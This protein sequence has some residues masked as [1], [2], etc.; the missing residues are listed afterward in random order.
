M[1]DSQSIYALIRRLAEK[2]I[3]IW[4]EEDALK[5][6]APKGALDAELKNEM[7]EQKPALIQFLKDQQASQRSIVAR[8]DKS[9]FP[10]SNAQ[11]RLWFIDQFSSDLEKGAYNI[12]VGLRINGA[13]NI[14][15]LK[16]AIAQV[17]ENHEVL[18]TYFVN[19]QGLPLQ[20]KVTSYEVDI[21]I[22]DIC[23]LTDSEK[24][25][26]SQELIEDNLTTTFDLSVWPLFK[27]DLIQLE[28]QRFIFLAT[29]HHIISDGWSME[30]LIREIATA[31]Q[32]YV[33]KDDTG[34]AVTPADPETLQYSD[35]AYWQTDYLD[36][37]RSEAQLNFWRNYLNESPVLEL[38]L[39]YKRVGDQLSAG[40]QKRLML[41][42]VLQGK[43]NNLASSQGVTLF[44]VLSAAF[45]ILLS[46]F[47][48]Q[49]DITLGIPVA[50][51][52]RPEWESLIGFFVNTL[53]LRTDLT[54]DPSFLSLL[55]QVQGNTLAIYSNQDLPFDR[56]V[57]ALVD[58]RD[59]A[60]TPLFQ[61]MFSLQNTPG[62]QRLSLSGLDLEVLE[63]SLP[64]SRFDMTWNLVEIEQGI[65]VNIEYSSDLFDSETMDLYFEYFGNLL[66]EIV[67][68]PQRKI[69]TYLLQPP[70][71][72]LAKQA[73]LNP[74]SIDY[75]RDKFIGEIFD[76][77]VKKFP[78]NSAL[79]G[80]HLLSSTSAQISQTYLE[81]K[82]SVNRLVKYLHDE[83]VRPNTRVLLMLPRSVEMTQCILALSKLGACYVPI[84]PDYPIERKQYIQKDSSATLLITTQAL[85][86]E[87][88]DIEQSKV[89]FL[90]DVALSK[91][92]SSNISVDLSPF[93][94][95]SL[96]ACIFYTSGSTG[97]PK[98]VIVPHRAIVRLVSNTNFADY[99]PNEVVAHISN[100]CFDASSME[101]WGAL[102]NGGRL[103]VIDQDCLLSINAFEQAL[104]EQRISIMF[105]SMGLFRVYANERPDMF[106]GLK[107]LLIGGEAVDLNA[108]QKVLKCTS[109]PSRLLNGYGPTENATFSTTFHI[110]SIRERTIS[111]PLGQAIHHSEAYITDSNGNLL[112]IGLIGELVCAGDG[113]ALGYLN[114]N[115]LSEEK[116]ITGY[117][118]EMP[119][120]RVYRS[121]DLA[122]YNTRGELILSGRLDE[123]IKLRGFRIEP[124]EISHQIE[125]FVEVQACCVVLKDKV[126]GEPHLV[127]YVQTTSDLIDTIKEQSKSALPAYMLPTYFEVIE[128]LPINAN[129]KIDKRAL[130]DPDWS[131]ESG[132]DYVAPRSNIERALA[133]I[134]A[135]L[136][137][138]DTPSVIANFFDLGG[139]S[140]LATQ[141]VSRIYDQ[142]SLELKVKQIF[143]HATIEALAIYIS[144]CGRATQPD[145]ELTIKAVVRESSAALSNAQRR[146]WFLHQLEPD[147]TAYGMP[148][149]ISIKG[150]LD[151][152]RLEKSLSSLVQRHES[153]RTYFVEESG[154]PR[155][156]IHA[157]CKISPLSHKVV[158]DAIELSTAITNNQAI[159]FNLETG[160]L[161]VVE[162][163]SVKSG[164]NKEPEF[165]LLMNMHH[166][167]SDGWSMQILQ[168]DLL[169][170]YEQDVD[171][172]P[173][174]DIQYID[175]AVWQNSVLDKAYNQSLLEHWQKELEGVEPVLHLPSTR[176]RPQQQS[177]SG[178]LVH[179]KINQD[180]QQR[181]LTYCKKNQ[182][183]SF[184]LGLSVYGI[185]LSKYSQQKDFCI[186]IPVSGRN[187]KD[188]ENIIGFFVNG[189][190]VRNDLKERLS[191]KD[192]VD[193]FKR[194]VLDAFSHQDLS[195]D[196]LVEAMGIK[197]SSRYQPLAQVAFSH[198]SIAKQTNTTIDNL[199]F[200]VLESENKSAK[201]DLLLSLGDTGER[202]DLACEFASDLF[203]EAWVK[204]FLV[205]YEFLI[206]AVISDDDQ[207]VD[208]LSWYG[209]SDIIEALSEKLERLDSSSQHADDLGTIL[210]AFPLS[211]NQDALYLDALINPHSRQNSIANLL[212]INHSID[213]VLWEKAFQQC[214]NHEVFRTE[215]M[216]LDLLG[217]QGVYQVIREHAANAFSYVDLRDQNH[218]FEALP[219]LLE[220][221]AYCLYD[222][223]KGPL[224]HYTLYQLGEAHFAAMLCAHHI[225]FDGI[226][227]KVFLDE[228]LD[229]Y[230]ALLV[231]K[232]ISRVPDN[233]QAFVTKQAGSIDS[234]A[235]IDFWARQSKNVEPLSCD[236][237]AQNVSSK[238]YV[239]SKISLSEAQSKAVRKFC[240]VH[241]ITPAIFFKALYALIVYQ[242]CRPE[243]DFH[244][245]EYAHGRDK[246]SMESYG[247]YY[248]QTP[249]IVAF[250]LFQQAN[251]DKSLLEDILVYAKRFQKQSRQWKDISIQA[252][253][254]LL[255]RSELGFIYNY[256]QFETQIDVLGTPAKSIFMSPR[257]DKQVQLFIREHSEH[258]E[259]L[260]LFSKSDFSDLRLLE[261][262]K[263]LAITALEEKTY[264]LE[265]VLN[266]EQPLLKSQQHAL[267]STDLD[268]LPIPTE[269]LLESFSQCSKSLTYANKIAV[270][271]VE[272][273]SFSEL[274][275]RS[276][277]LAKYL[278]EQ[279]KLAPQASVA[280]HMPLNET[281]IIAL[282]ALI[283][284]GLS[285]VPIQPDYP[286]ERIK[287]IV[288]TASISLVIS[289][290]GLADAVHLEKV[291]LTEHIDP[292]YVGSE[293]VLL[294]RQSNMS[295]NDR[296]YTIFTSGSTGL[297]KGA[298]VS[299]Q[300]E[301]N[302]LAWYEVAVDI[303]QNDKCIVIS[304]PGFDLTQ[305]NLFAFLRKGATLLLPDLTI[306]DPELIR[307]CIASEH[308]THI[309]CAPSAF[310][311]LL[312]G[313]ES[314]W[315]QLASLRWVVLGGEP[316][317]LSELQAWYQS[318]H[319]QARLMNSYGPT[320]CSD[321][322]SAYELSDID[323]E[324][325]DPVPLGQAIDNTDIRI[326]DRFGN[327]L[328]PGLVGEIAIG[329][330]GL[331]LGYINNPK[332]NT[333][334][335]VN[336]HRMSSTHARDSKVY[337]SGDLGRINAKG[338][339]EIL[340]R[341]DFQIK[342]RGQRIELSEIETQLRRVSS[343]RDALVI[344]YQDRLI[345][346][347]VKQNGAK[348]D[349]DAESEKQILALLSESLPSYMLPSQIIMLDAWPLN[350]NGKIERN[351]LPEP[352]SQKANREIIKARDEYEQAL[353]DIWSEV[354]GIDEISIL[355]NFF[356]L[357][358]H[359]LLATKTVSR[360]KEHFQVEFPL[361]ALFDLH[362][363]ADLAEYIKTLRWAID[364]KDQGASQ[365]DPNEKRDEGFL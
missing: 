249:F 323:F 188:V 99:G 267:P 358:G 277:T 225:I 284:A 240:R 164:G 210:N 149:A 237:A 258:F 289:E 116:F 356:D 71:K 106:S 113:L 255:P 62:D 103:H 200:E 112:P 274:D 234:Q 177:F 209:Q 118:K 126:P 20:E 90:E 219:D 80:H 1:I 98:G 342:L 259:F 186:G 41:T 48:Q 286:L 296:L 30:V 134:W 5:F 232:T 74:P 158:S 109:P 108:A 45:N 228:M 19:R 91:E 150:N 153:L 363:L 230:Q 201:Y 53:V 16:Y 303:G 49:N 279:R 195:A 199:V 187:Q 351:S 314:S 298:Q 236:S 43:L 8:P 318:A 304:A 154:E 81:L 365:L 245:L 208:R 308:V 335:F 76:E 163:L 294:A 79:S 100:V 120:K 340:G 161:F 313:G 24:A 168:Q 290:L 328:P 140:L 7:I 278:I 214:Q 33:E 248:Q 338:L 17:I 145:D 21:S 72:I 218:S 185:L 61:V 293:S 257:A 83:G 231:Q 129:G 176:P 321:V 180:L 175:F 89:L 271:G 94:S 97:E 111:I 157:D 147:S 135:D 73:S 326:L 57:E 309:N 142:F 251:F 238:A 86:S 31:Y 174:L 348:V 273:I 54:G 137:T 151:I 331:G 39:D 107:D 148:M 282:Y 222:I 93:Q 27:L 131:S 216:E 239:Q 152:P 336:V 28:G 285:Y 23:K 269:F 332:L 47:S 324:R 124:S 60:Y 139:H 37:Q 144:Q 364:A 15:A 26:Q 117:I 56:V 179:H 233:F 242:Y 84:D 202:L 299:H 29:M 329:G 316:L 75:P 183:T 34:L 215:I 121:G 156:K 220:A 227:G 252:Q 307:K 141:L 69:S 133:D 173:A 50:N 207:S 25:L 317:V 360:V 105:L 354:L 162:L 194:K 64:H 244:I 40:K 350:A 266:S 357:G 353:V 191:V 51:R 78:Q 125:Q 361:K 198:Q 341:K 261:R 88:L 217:E 130:P 302:L 337:L 95:D 110:E 115:T 63:N 55:K 192:C 250:E 82:Q 306:F 268:D 264:S 128:S 166:I 11:Q 212:E 347:V 315:E 42:K 334:N 104:A 256:T 13:L 344:L 146:L 262:L 265:F 171:E 283:K 280:L 197:P 127:A 349:S 260:L 223:Q 22:H 281:Y 221:D 18:Q 70:E 6:K 253:S 291:L 190:V 66:E 3:K 211:A 224:Y 170:I 362:T 295:P 12:P 101:L 65:A 123:Q 67:L 181:I 346:Y 355:D 184:V 44:M 52:S 206:D 300:G 241:A 38:P 322:V 122:R 243:A 160:P 288:E 35:Y 159:T 333:E 178:G 58:Q 68:D 292:N 235:C 189:L 276:D 327:D 114:K 272:S 136:L 85:S 246:E 96:E 226:S 92:A 77:T 339:L 138:I 301:A 263:Q 352:N 165:T 132:N 325:G 319:C 46:R 196:L 275:K 182:L 287:H 87:Y 9:L 2:K 32:Y 297:P 345:A 119:D 143:D 155:Q 167:I 270:V 59:S 36:E 172:L 14:D 254:A 169:A 4:L 213:T 203:D 312:D 229:R 310:Y 343:I 305:K 320:E 102:L 10:I 204:R 247:V 359:S 311:A 193:Q 205:H 330:A